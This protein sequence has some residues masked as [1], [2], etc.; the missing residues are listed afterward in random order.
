MNEYRLTKWLFSGTKTG[1]HLAETSVQKI[2]RAARKK[3]NIPQHATSHTLRHSFATHLLD[4]GVDLRY[5]QNCSGMAASKWRV[6]PMLAK[7]IWA[8]TESGGSIDAKR[9]GKVERIGVVWLSL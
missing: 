2:V 1:R 3:A 7:R 4:A 9:V 5:I 8:Y 6:I